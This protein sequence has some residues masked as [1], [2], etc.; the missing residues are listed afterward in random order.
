MS[1]F[2]GV[3]TRNAET[4]SEHSQDRHQIQVAAGHNWPEFDHEIG[5]INVIL[6]SNGTGKTNLLKTLRNQLPQI[7]K[8]RGATRIAQI[9]GNR[10]LFTSGQ[11]VRRRSEAAQWKSLTQQLF[12]NETYNESALQQF[13]DALLEGLCQDHSRVAQEHSDD[14][15][16][17][18]DQ[19]PPGPIPKRKR[20]RL[21]RF[22]S[23]WAR[24]F[25]DIRLD[26]DVTIVSVK[27]SKHDQE[28]SITQLSTGE[29]QVFLLLGR[30]FVDDEPEIFLVDEPD[31]NLN[32]KLAEG[33]WSTIEQTH[34]EKSLFIYGTHLTSFA[35]R[36][37]VD[38]VFLIDGKRT[39]EIDGPDG[40][41]ALPS[42]DRAEF[43]GAIPS[44]V[45]RDKVL[46]VEGEED[47][48]D[49]QVYEY[50]LGPDSGIEVIPL[51]DC[52]SV[53][54]AVEGTTPWERITSGITVAGVVDRDYRAEET[55]RNIASDRLVVLPF[56]E[57]ESV[58]CHPDLLE[59]AFRGRFAEDNRPTRDQVE[60]RY[61]NIA[62]ANA[63]AIAI[64][65]TQERLRSKVSISALS[66]EEIRDIGDEH[67][68]KATLVRKRDALRDYVAT[69]DHESIFDEEMN[70]MR[71]AIQSDDPKHLLNLV[72]GKSLVRAACGFMKAPDAFALLKE[73]RHQVPCVDDVPVLRDLRARLLRLF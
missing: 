72:E 6:G 67:E 42:R 32:P 65:R 4:M 9:D 31:R 27:C 71:A 40:F 45:I 61:R 34:H 49:R 8:Q 52:D 46:V 21:D 60:T 41:L 19:E 54:K 66:A 12:A 37:G 64:R 29:K 55:L 39:V 68:A 56:H 3:A 35:L 13:A 53:R 17:I 10:V 24:I 1:V 33:F 43:L 2:S 58:L 50:I 63:V 22:V 5:R 18:A 36:P 73:I 70:Q 28:Y 11:S 20:S 25:P 30:F 26:F 57:V 16:A 51:R 38:R 7:Q 59:R 44:I 23:M 62:Q 47:G 69:M 15:N 48:I 14:C